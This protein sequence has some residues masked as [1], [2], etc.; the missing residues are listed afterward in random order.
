MGRN[1]V[2]VLPRRWNYVYKSQQFCE[3]TGFK[4][5][6]VVICHVINAQY[7]CGH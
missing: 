3:Q 5:G 1:C 4:I 2:L 6:N 7:V